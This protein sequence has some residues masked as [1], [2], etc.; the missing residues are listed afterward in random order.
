MPRHDG[1]RIRSRQ[2]DNQISL[3]N[4]ES[5][6]LVR[7]R[8]S[9]RLHIESITD[10]G[11]SLFHRVSTPQNHA[12]VSIHYPLRGALAERFQIITESLGRRARSQKTA[13]CA[14]LDRQHRHRDRVAPPVPA[15]TE[16]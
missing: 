10:T 2:T 6:E 12:D 1:I 7:L 16:T 15:L 14:P 9:R 11:H 4:L 8:V 13:L 5:I 3:N